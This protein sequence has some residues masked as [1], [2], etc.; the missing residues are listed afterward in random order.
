MPK[1]AG[2]GV[3]DD[4]YALGQRPESGDAR[5]V[6]LPAGSNMPPAS[7]SVSM[8]SPKRTTTG[9]AMQ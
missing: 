7:T 6:K 5:L 2:P 1:A 4:G 3:E 9:Y 8:N